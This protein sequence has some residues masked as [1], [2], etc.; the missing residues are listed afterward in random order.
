MTKFNPENKDVITYGEA[1]RPAMDITDSEDAKQYKEAYI[2]YTQKF[3][4]DGARDDDMTAEEIVNVNL[5]YF[6]GYYDNETR[7]PVERLFNTAHPI[8]GS[9]KENGV[10]TPE[11]AFEAGVKEAQKNKA[12]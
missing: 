11:E 9:I 2:A 12:V 8:F 3:L 10:P 1:L 7:A 4:D 5:G 6:A